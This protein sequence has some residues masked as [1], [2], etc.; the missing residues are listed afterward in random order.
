MI[1]FYRPTHASLNEKIFENTQ[2]LGHSGTCALGHSSTWALEAI[3]LRDSLHTSNC[4]QKDITSRRYCKQK[5][6]DIGNKKILETTDLK[7]LRIDLAHLSIWRGGI[8]ILYKVTQLKS[9]KI[10]CTQKLV[11]LTYALRKDFMLYRSNLILNSN[12]SLAFFRQK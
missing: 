11:N 1:I 3:N 5:K 6:K 7:Y 12:Q 9:L 10:K 8:G 2:V 4:K